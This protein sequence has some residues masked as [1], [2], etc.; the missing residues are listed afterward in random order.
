[1]GRSESDEDQKGLIAQRSQ[2]FKRFERFEDRF[3]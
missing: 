1:M 2:I 3:W